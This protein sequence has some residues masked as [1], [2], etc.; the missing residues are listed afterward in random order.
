MPGQIIA[1]K[2]FSIKMERKVLSFWK[3]GLVP[4]FV[5]VMQ[6][7]FIKIA[8]LVLAQTSKGLSLCISTLLES[9]KICAFRKICKLFKMFRP[10]PHY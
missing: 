2:P 4:R 3:A 6:K 8:Y 10:F 5:Q 1:I 7:S 9:R